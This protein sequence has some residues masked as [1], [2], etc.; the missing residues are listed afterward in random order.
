MKQLILVLTVIV[1]TVI[2]AFAQVAINTT[3]SEPDPSAMLDITSTDKGI[4]IPRVT[5]VQRNDILAPQSGLLVY[6]TNTQSFWYYNN[7]QSDWVELIVDGNLDIDGLL[8][9]KSDGA[10]VFMGNGSGTN[11][12]GNNYNSSLGVYS[13]KLNTSGSHNTVLGSDGMYR[14]TTGSRN[15][16]IGR[17]A[18][19]YNQEGN[20]N[21]IIGYWAG[22][23]STNH[24]K[25]GNVFLGYMAGYNETS[26]NKLYISNSST[27]TP[28]IGGDFS[29]GEL[30]FNGS[31]KITGGS[32]G[33]GKV[34]TSDADGLA[35]W[36]DNA[37]ASEINGLLDGI[38]DNSNLY[39]GTTTGTLDN[40][41]NRNT[42]I[43]IKTLYWNETGNNNTAIGYKSSYRNA[44]GSSNTAM[45]NNALYFNTEKSNL[46]AIGDSAL[47]YNGNNSPTSIQATLNTAVGS[48][49][50]LN[51]TTGYNNSGFGSS[52]MY[53]NTTGHHNTSMGY[54]S[55]GK[56]STGNFNS[57]I[58]T[59][60]SL[61]NT[62]G[63]NNVSMGYAANYYNNGSNNVTVGF[64]AGYGT[65]GDNKSGNIFIGYK[66]GYSETGSNKLYI[67]NS[68][69]TSPLI[70]GDFS[71]QKL[72]F[73]GMVGIGTED[74]QQSLHVL[75]SSVLSS[76]LIAPQGTANN[77]SELLLAEDDDFSYGMSI[78]YDGGDNR[79]YFLGKTS[80]DTM[81]SHFTISRDGDIGFGTSTPLFRYHFHNSENSNN[82]LYLTPAG[83]TGDSSSI[84]FAE[85]DDASTGMYFMYDGQNN[86]LGLYGVTGY[87]N[88][89]PHLLV[90][91][92]SGNI[93]I[94]GRNFA[95]DYK[96]SVEG[97]VI[98]E[99]I[100]VSMQSNWPDY[101]FTDEYDL[102]PI[103]NLRKYIDEKGHLPN[104]PPASEVEELGI[105]LGVMQKLMMEK[106]EELSLYII[107]QDERIKAL[108]NEIKSTIEQ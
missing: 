54:Y 10:S 84:F 31:I 29:A 82:M 75:G 25:T 5:T 85:D 39:L 87:G 4:L 28:L 51:N 27:T 6:D 36:E 99:E 44:S 14:N 94:G 16:A 86:D 18:N 83:S 74:P 60:S 24:N 73:N 106:I 108:E 104:I 100:R 107:Q 46:V 78:K 102:M 101:V 81:G 77:D 8:D 57:A 17:R 72:G 53:F 23:G 3:G 47:Y 90:D 66:A 22:A 80:T 33:S 92:N 21:T 93:A 19:Y 96:L 49:A 42:G 67:H 55:L 15:T 97:K 37:A 9:A 32:P 95:D 58:G 63:E 38:T 61:S 79:L 62:N 69:T 68:E 52:S 7:T 40:G 13:L 26:D 89:G 41:D 65:T 50:M 1:L 30:Y 2:S 12:D 105:E 59:Y 64:K 76:V 103:D 43:G 56:N 70:Y 88:Y 34:L 45:G 91:R 20:N 11:D 35:S 48:K 71:T 98:C